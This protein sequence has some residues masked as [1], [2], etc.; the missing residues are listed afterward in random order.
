MKPKPRKLY[1]EMV[2]ESAWNNNLRAIFNRAQWDKLRK[3]VY[4]AYDHKCAV[5]KSDRK[6]AAHEIWA[7][8]DAKH[9]QTLAG[10]VALCSMCH[11]VKHIGLAQ[12][13]ASEDRL[14]FGAII[15]HY[16]R[17]NKCTRK[18][19]EQDLADAESQ[20]AERSKH[21]WELILGEKDG[22]TP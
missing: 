9:T 7:Y 19:F 18:E 4:A 6:L 20:W 8:D 17:I 13:L 2:P 12:H 16:C 1:I 22:N 14:N 3:Q 10:I 5:C 21:N 11:H 15:G